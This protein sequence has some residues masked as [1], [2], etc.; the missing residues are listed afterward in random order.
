[1]AA[2]K[3]GDNW[4]TV[5]GTSKADSINNS[6]SFVTINAGKGNDSIKNSAENVII[7]GG[8]GNNTIRNSGEEAVLVGGGSGKNVIISTNG[9][10]TL[11]GGTGNN[12]LTGGEGANVFIH[13]NGATDVI[14]NYDLSEDIII[15]EQGKVAQSLTSDDGNDII[16]KIADGDNDLGTITVKDV[17]GTYLTIYDED[18]LNESKATFFEFS[19]A[20]IKSAVKTFEE[21]KDIQSILTDGENSDVLSEIKA[22]NPDLAKQIAEA[23]TTAYESGTAYLE[24]IAERQ[25][26]VSGSSD[27]L[28]SSSADSDNNSFNNMI[29]ALDFEATTLNELAN[30]GKVGTAGAVIGKTLSKV[31]GPLSVGLALETCILYDAMLYS[32]N[33]ADWI[34]AGS[35]GETQFQ[36]LAM[37]REQNEE[38]FDNTA[39]ANMDLVFTVG[40]FVA[41]GVMSALG[42]V[43]A[44]VIAVAGACFAAPFVVNWA[45][46][47]FVAKKL[48]EEADKLQIAM[49]ENFKEEIHNISGGSGS[50]GSSGSGSSGG[51]SGSNTK[52]LQRVEVSEIYVAP[53][54]YLVTTYSDGSK[55]IGN[56]F[57]NYVMNKYDDGDGN[58]KY[59]DHPKKKV[60]EYDKEGKFVDWHWEYIYDANG[61]HPTV[62]GSGANLNGGAGNDFISNH[63][64]SVKIGGGA[65]NDS[66]YNDG[67]KVTI[68]GGAG[69]DEIYNYGDSV[70]IEGGA[71]N[72][73]ITNW[74]GNNV[75][76]EGGAGNDSIRN[77]GGDNVT[78][79]GGNGNNTVSGSGTI[80]T[81]SGDDSIYS[82]N[83]SIDAGEGNNTV[84]GSGTIKT[85]S[86][87]DYV[88]SYSKS[89]ISA[90]KGNDTIRNQGFL[91]T[92]QSGAGNDSIYNSSNGSLTAI[93]GGEGYDTV[94]NYGA[95]VTI[96]TGADDDLIYNSSNASLTAING[97]DGNDYV[98]NYSS[99]VTIDGGDGRDFV[100][101]MGDEIS[102]VGGEGNDII[103]NR[104]EVVTIE[105]GAG[106]DSIRN[107]ASDLT[108]SGGAGDDT[109]RIVYGDNILIEYKEGDG[110]DV[111]YGFTES[112]TLKIGDGEKDTYSTVKSGNNVIVTVGK[113]KITLKGAATLDE[114][115]IDGKDATL[116]K[117]TNGSSAKQ[118]IGA[119]IKTADAS[120][121]TKAFR[122]T[123]NK[124]ANTIL[125]GSG[126][127]TFFGGNGD[128]FI[129]GDAGNDKL[130]GQN[131]NDTLWGGTGNDTMTGGKGKDLFIYEAG[132]DVITDYA[133][134]DKI[135]IGADVTAASLNGSD[136][137][138]VIGSNTL[139][140]KNVG[141]NE[142][143]LVDAEGSELTTIIGSVI[144]DDENASKVTLASG[145]ETGD[146]SERTVAIRV[147]GNALNNTIL[148]GLG[149]D[150]LYGADGNDYLVGNDGSDKLY[151]QNGNDMLWGGAG[152]DTLEGGDGADVFIYNAG[153]GKDVISDFANDDMLLITGT[154]SASYNSSKKT[155]AFK[156]DSTSSAITL[157]N[158]TATSFNINGDAYK[159]SGSKLVKK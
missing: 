121:C 146:A 59:W 14:K 136:A 99:Y 61:N 96:D 143:T 22:V 23:L 53:Q 103:N 70:K 2:I 25:A 89:S 115:N 16:L 117:L 37:I 17:E 9:N 73:S 141:R 43:G 90:G 105:A 155:I 66:I 154:F 123:G 38:I 116:L 101:N 125:G 144:Y 112:S 79:N 157:K 85:G 151:G 102:I 11:L 86:G 34:A 13:R 18:T 3:N 30:I 132:N 72:D 80:K 10:S 8:A 106:D 65:D 29:S 75:K 33:T 94:R 68:S 148:G 67:N 20:Y 108:I 12:T 45:Y 63:G 119:S 104:G 55:S 145:I 40:G 47:K 54:Y 24:T 44:P 82:S 113:E 49:R 97:G 92:I 137:V 41:T 91:V 1:M 107:S 130:Y 100:N 42:I 57:T 124:L 36:K 122:L 62:S 87:D 134:G 60:N 135:L 158:F 5:N 110:N 56:D 133:A 93:D 21:D 139:T 31:T 114:L 131:G 39:K 78:I 52:W 69:N 149:K 84:S 156:V 32:E 159:I 83:S 74:S 150:S 109:I 6:G 77:Y 26:S 46:D 19:A 88:D 111:I 64:D 48:D 118:T 4:K 98:L 147:E 152:N 138:F 71:G 127:D 28:L 95:S 50:G 76:I 27:L 153:E 126:K 140:V 7:F 58:G 120:E 15:L 51:S 81:G 35:P 128:D 142:L 129:A